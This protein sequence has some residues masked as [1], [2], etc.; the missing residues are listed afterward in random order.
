MC[1]GCAGMQRGVASSK[2]RHFMREFVGLRHSS[3]VMSCEEVWGEN[4]GR[5]EYY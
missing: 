3:R 4:D 1:F 2:R 5:E